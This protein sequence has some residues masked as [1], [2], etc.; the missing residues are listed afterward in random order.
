MPAVLVLI[1]LNNFSEVNGV[2][3][4]AVGDD[5]LTAT[6]QS[7][8]SFASDRLDLGSRDAAFAGRLDGDHFGIV[9]PD[10]E[11]IEATAAVADHPL[12][13][14]ADHPVRSHRQG[15][16]RSVVI[17]IPAQGRSLTSVLGRGFRLLNSRAREVGGGSGPWGR[18]G[19]DGLLPC[20]ERDLAAA[21]ASDQLSIALQPKLEIATGLVRGAEALIRWNHPQ[22]GPIAPPEFISTA[23]KSGL[24]FNLGL[25][26]LREAWSRA[27]GWMQRVG[28]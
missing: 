21:M 26:V 5:L 12:P 24:I 14:A 25:R 22:Y 1:D 4:P 10:V 18:P 2:W 23:E 9:I 7:V 3:G 6:A 15:K 19:S 16:L 28:A 20:V 11:S 13:S 17:P 27:T 8:A